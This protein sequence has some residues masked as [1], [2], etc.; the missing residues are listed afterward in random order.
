VVRSRRRSRQLVRDRQHAALP[1]RGVRRG[2][3]RGH[4]GAG[5][6]PYIVEHERNGL[7]VPIGDPDA[8]AAG[9]LRVLGD[10]EL[11]DR[12]VAGGRADCAAR[13]AWTA[14]REEWRQL[15]AWLGDRPAALEP[16]TDGG[17][18]WSSR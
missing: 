2:H 17:A 9:V 7:I 1:D 4:H 6:I 8:L 15:Y 12:L 16:A 18:A 3:A 13:Y 11:A 5:G 10:G 14:A